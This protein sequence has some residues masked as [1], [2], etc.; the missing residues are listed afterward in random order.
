MDEEKNAYICTKKRQSRTVY[1]YK[2]LTQNIS[3]R[4]FFDEMYVWVI[5]LSISICVP[6]FLRFL[7]RRSY[8]S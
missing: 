2:K 3:S 7:R 1:K 6:I 8:V 5:V 4:V